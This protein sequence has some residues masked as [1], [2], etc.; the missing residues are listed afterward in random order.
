MESPRVGGKEG[1]LEND[2]LNIVGVVIAI[3]W[4]MIYNRR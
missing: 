1:L 4:T 3:R 2:F